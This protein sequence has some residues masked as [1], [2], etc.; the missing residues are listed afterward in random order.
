MGSSFLRLKEPKSQTKWVW[1]KIFTFNLD[2]EEVRQKI[3]Q[4]LEKR[5]E[6]EDS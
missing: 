3:N 5:E 4:W 6:H 1:A 2:S